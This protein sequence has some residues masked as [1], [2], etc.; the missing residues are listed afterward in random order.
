M[1][2][3]RR[4][5]DQLEVLRNGTVQVREAIEVLRDGEVIA[6]QFHRSTVSIE[7]EVP[8]LSYLPA[9]AVAVIEA[10]RTL[11]KRQAGLA[12]KAAR[13]AGSGQNS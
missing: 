11:E 1:L 2:E 5:V 4:V 3:E 12:R 9:D 8:D 10:A 13:E 6:R 7:D